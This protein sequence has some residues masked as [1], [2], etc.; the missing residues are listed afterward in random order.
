LG[1]TAIEIKSGYGLDLESELKM[2]RVISRLRE[3]Q[4][5]VIKATFLGAHD[6]PAEF[7]EDRKKYIDLIV[8]QMLP[9]VAEERLA[10]Y[11]DVFCESN[12]FS[13]KEMEQILDAGQQHGLLPKVHVNQFTSIGGIQKAVDMGAIS[14]DHL[15]VMTEQDVQAL[16]QTYRLKYPN[17]LTIATLLPSCSF[18]LGLDYAPGRQLIENGVGVALASDFNPGS[19]PSHNLNFV[20]SL[21]NLKMGLTPNEAYNA[22]TINAAHAIESAAVVGSIT[23]GARA[24]LL[25]SERIQGLESIG[26]HFG[27]SQI[28][29]V[30]LA[31]KFI[32]M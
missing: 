4:N 15:E 22:L 25:F 32:E 14:V 24:D 21:A 13:V 12:Y 31:G 1:T 3:S 17:K 30:M 23:K 6:I 26:Y 9:Q 7:K 11:I 5:M 20:M 2:L 29:Q 8:H 27:E 10:D 19:T 28:D 16:R 18:F